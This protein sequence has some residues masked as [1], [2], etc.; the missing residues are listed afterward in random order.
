MVHLCGHSQS[1]AKAYQDDQSCKDPNKYR[2]EPVLFS[3][4][5]HLS[6]AKRQNHA[7]TSAP[8]S[9]ARAADVSPAKAA[10][11]AQSPRGAQCIFR[12][13]ALRGIRGLRIDLW[14][15]SLDL[16]IDL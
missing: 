3:S 15:V 5:K 2:S 11:G 13:A 16:F 6:V 4:S 9:P 14:L 8:G 7:K 12:P 10:P 1:N